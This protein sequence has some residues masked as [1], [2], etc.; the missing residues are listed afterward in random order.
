M[1]LGLLIWPAHQHMERTVEIATSFGA[2]DVLAGTAIFIT[3]LALA[4]TGIKRWPALSFGIFWFFTGLAP[5]S[6]IAVPINGLLY[7]H[8]LYLPMIGF[9]L[10]FV[11]LGNEA[12]KK[13]NIRKI[14]TAVFAAWVVFLGGLAIRRNT[15]WY[16]PIRF[17]NQILRYNQR[18]YRVYNN[19]GMAYADEGDYDQAVSAYEKAIALDPR[20]AVAYYN[21]GNA[22]R[23]RGQ[24]DTAV[25][26]YKKSFSADPGFTYAA[27]A[28]AAYYLDQ[29]NYAEALPYVKKLLEFHP[30]DPSLQELYLQLKQTVDNSSA[31]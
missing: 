31:F 13:W 23:D 28:L 11:W 6:N 27:S 10:A 24:A 14:M 17:Y 21:L 29:K 26:Y 30:N 25:E 2:P 18:S 1:Y 7:E 19:L 20:V 16:D 9:F 4:V 15:D 12:A 3:F 8:W 22:F 5:T